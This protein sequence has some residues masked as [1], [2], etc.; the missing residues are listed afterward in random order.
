MDENKNLENGNSN[1]ETNNTEN[2]H[3]QNETNNPPN[4]GNNNTV[5][6]NS[7]AHQTLGILGLVFGIIALVISFI[8]CLGI[9]ALFPGII[10]VILSIIGLVLAN[11]N[12]ITKKGLII[13]ALV[14]SVLA[15]LIAGYQFYVITYYAKSF[16]EASSYIEEMD[17]AMNDTDNDEYSDEEEYNDNETSNDSEEYNEEENTDTNN[18]NDD[19]KTTNWEKEFNEIIAEKDYDKILDYYEEAINEYVKLAKEAKAGN[20]D[21]AMKTLPELTKIGI[22]GSKV[23][24]IAPYFNDE[25]K[26]RFEAINKKANEIEKTKK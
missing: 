2:T 18:Y 8:P 11:K 9:Y 26:K 19:E 5:N 10:A 16:H 23:I 24:V 12:G 1:N 25:Q 4:N 7:N 22:I 13:A 17:K 20:Y 15:T 21:A 3:K 6:N 14:I